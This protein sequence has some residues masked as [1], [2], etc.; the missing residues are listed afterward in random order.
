MQHCF[1]LVFNRLD[2]AQIGAVDAQYIPYWLYSIASREHMEKNWNEKK[3]DAL[4]D[5][6]PSHANIIVSHIFFKIRKDDAK[7]ESTK[8]ELTLKNRIGVH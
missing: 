2:G 8:P 3:R 7:A 6:A 1:R 5:G 4:L